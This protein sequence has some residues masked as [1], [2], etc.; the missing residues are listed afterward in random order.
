MKF[1]VA[2]LTKPV[3]V[4]VRRQLSLMKPPSMFLGGAAILL[5]LGLTGLHYVATHSESS[6]VKGS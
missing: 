6:F 1:K 4:A 3:P 5:F 2:F